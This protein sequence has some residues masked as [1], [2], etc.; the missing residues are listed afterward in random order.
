MKRRTSFLL[1]LALV[2]ALVLSGCSGA[3]SQ[4]ATDLSGVSISQFRSESPWTELNGNAPEFDAS[5]LTRTDP[6]ET[7]SGL[8]SLGRCGV[9][10]ANIC[11]ELMPTEERE[12]IGQVKPTGW[13]TAKYDGV[14]GKYLY[15]RC[16]L[17]GFQ[18][19]GE[20][21]NEKNLITGNPVRM[22]TQGMLP[23]ENKVAD[24][25][26]S[27][28]NHVLYRV[29]PVFEGSDLVAQGVQ[30]EAYS[31]EDQGEGVCFNVFCYNAQPGVGIE[32]ASGESW[33]DPTVDWVGFCDD[34]YPARTRWR[35]KVPNTNSH[36]FHKPDCSGVARISAQNKQGSDEQLLEL[37]E[38]GYSPCGTCNPLRSG[39]RAAGNGEPTGL[40]L[41]FGMWASPPDGASG[42][43]E[44]RTRTHGIRRVLARFR[45]KDKKDKMLV[46]RV[47]DRRISPRRMLSG[48]SQ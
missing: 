4:A 13:H 17:I 6:F 27:T 30:M 16:H 18:L 21:A 29:T 25:V 19:A 47:N 26:K 40:T 45:V 1:A 37:I 9:A 2:F 42:L 44:L 10:Y 8:D 20:N 46:R 28:G 36:K 7:Y 33:S 3:P 11:M 22:N 24:Y 43:R 35:P 12:S 5:D 14:D 32:Y 23:F 41:V 31:V 34:L 15:N 38:Q 39:E 48:R